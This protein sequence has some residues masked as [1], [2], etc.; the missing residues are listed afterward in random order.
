MLTPALHILTFVANLSAH[1]THIPQVGPAHPVTIPTAGHGLPP[2]P[3]PSLNANGDYK[4]VEPRP[5]EEHKNRHATTLPEKHAPTGQAIASEMR[6]IAKPTEASAVKDLNTFN[7]KGHV[8]GLSVKTSGQ[9]DAHQRPATP[10]AID[11]SWAAGKSGATRK[12]DSERSQK[13]INSNNSSQSID[14]LPPLLSPLPASLASP[15]SYED[16]PQISAQDPADDDVDLKDSSPFSLPPLLSPTLPPEIERALK[17]MK[18]TSTNVRSSVERAYENSRQADAPGVAKKKPKQKGSKRPPPIQD[19]VDRFDEDESEVE[20][21]IVHAKQA[22]A[23]TKKSM[24]IK[25][26][27]GRRNSKNINRL[28]ALSPRSGV[29]KS[30]TAHPSKPLPAATKSDKK[31]PHA[32]DDQIEP[33]A[34]RPKAPTH[35]EVPRAGAQTTS[36]I[37][38]PNASLSKQPQ[39][40]LHNNPKRGD[41]LKSIG[42]GRI[43]SSDSHV[44]TPGASASTPIAAPNA[45]PKAAVVYA[46]NSIEKPKSSSNDF[47]LADV[48]HHKAQHTKNVELGTSL[49]RRMDRLF[50]LKEQNPGPVSETDAKL[51]AIVALES[52]AAYM[53]AFHAQDVQRKLERKLNAGEHWDSLL[54]LL[55]FVTSRCKAHST[56]HAAA[57][58]ATAVCTEALSV[59]HFDRLAND[60]AIHSSDYARFKDTMVNNNS[61]RVSAWRDYH[62]LASRNIA[63]ERI[64]TG[65]PIHDVVAALSRTLA[66]TSTKLGVVW[67]KRIDF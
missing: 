38:S 39:K 4:R 66:D 60:S 51:G 30:A 18:S 64:D 50:K 13:V 45:T 19:H 14:N 43:S 9:V 15:G 57:L 6:K 20:N 59:C 22:P 1:S 11:K 27:Y 63:V 2:K 34:K 46:P 26:R 40:P 67:E 41:A 5:K 24:I 21:I 25:L 55:P 17:K 62:E 56:L 37:R 47:K 53:T 36:T 65:T 44:R 7:P 32:D 35:L 33:S 48:E 28:L 3:P 31:R 52:V 42:M 12:T 54:S 8:T 58:A 10:E 23:S 29:T 61:K 49:K 16:P